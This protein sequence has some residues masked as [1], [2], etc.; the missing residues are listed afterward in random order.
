MIMANVRR[1]VQFRDNSKKT[2][3]GMEN[4]LYFNRATVPLIAPH[5]FNRATVPLRE[6]HLLTYIYY[7][8]W[9]FAGNYVLLNLVLA[10]LLDGFTMGSDSSKDELIDDFETIY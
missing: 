5:L 7:A 8:I 2:S 10:I 9:I 4:V 6:P 1:A 3:K